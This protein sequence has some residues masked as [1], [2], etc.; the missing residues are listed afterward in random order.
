[1]TMQWPPDSG[2]NYY[3]TIGFYPD[4]GRPA[5]VFLAGAKSGSDQDALLD[6]AMIAVSKLLQSGADPKELSHTFGGQSLI[7]AVALEIANV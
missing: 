5:E 3:L 4:T 6:D 7:G 2:K 1:M